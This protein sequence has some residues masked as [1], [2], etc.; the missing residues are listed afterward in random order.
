MTHDRAAKPTIRETV[1]NWADNKQP[2]TTSIQ[3]R[4]AL[5]SA[6]EWREMQDGDK[7]AEETRERGPCTGS[8]STSP[9]SVSVADRA[10]KEGE[11]REPDLVIERMPDWNYG[12][13]LNA[14]DASCIAIGETAQE[15]RNNGMRE[16]LRRATQPPQE[17]V[18]LREALAKHRYDYAEIDLVAQ[19]SC[20][21]KYDAPVGR[22]NGWDWWAIHFEAVLAPD[23]AETE[24]AIRKLSWDQPC[25]G[26]WTAV[27]RV[28]HVLAILRAALTR[29]EVGK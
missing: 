27:V 6:L 15:A 14:S 19:C 1:Y 24:E 2:G 11:G 12:A 25:N 20:G 9:I 4:D 23:F 28:E 26:K 16:L 21:W 3:D 22:Y 18:S 13:F 29:G 8:D 5:V 7:D 10:A 17:L